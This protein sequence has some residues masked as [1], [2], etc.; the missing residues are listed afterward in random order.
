MFEHC[1]DGVTENDFYEYVM[2][3]YH[4]ILTDDEIPL[5]TFKERFDLVCQVHLK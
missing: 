1:E 5:K 3:A 4:E 2:E